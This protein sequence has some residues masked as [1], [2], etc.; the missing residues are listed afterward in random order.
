MALSIVSGTRARTLQE[1]GND[2]YD[3]PDIADGCYGIERR[4][5]TFQQKRFAPAA[6]AAGPTSFSRR[7]SGRPLDRPRMTDRDHRHAGVIGGNAERLWPARHRIRPSDAPPNPARWLASRDSRWR[8][9]YRA[10]P[11]DSAAVVAEIRVSHRQQ[12]Y[13]RILTQPD[14]LRPDIQKPVAS[15]R[16]RVNRSQT[17]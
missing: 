17:R 7:R 13:W 14:C 4:P 1:S 6:C 3:T 5:Q 11:N 15:R 10:A 16:H 9:R 2:W 12:Q 8:R